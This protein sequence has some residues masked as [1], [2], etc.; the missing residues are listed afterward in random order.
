MKRWP[1]GRFFGKRIE[2]VESWS[3]DRNVE[4]NLRAKLFHT[5]RVIELKNWRSSYKFVKKMTLF[6]IQSSRYG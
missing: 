2:I 5:L 4:E 6:S 3:Y 1:I